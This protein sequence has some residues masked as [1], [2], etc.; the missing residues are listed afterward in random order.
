MTINNDDDWKA[1]EYKAWIAEHP[2]LDAI[3]TTMPPMPDHVR[4]RLQVKVREVFHQPDTVAQQLAF[5]VIRCAELQA[6]LNRTRKA[7]ASAQMYLSLGLNARA[8]E[9]L[10]R[11]FLDL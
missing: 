5:C 2:D 7:M 11:G 8:M 1:L 6:S 4:E 10:Q 9:Y 3:E